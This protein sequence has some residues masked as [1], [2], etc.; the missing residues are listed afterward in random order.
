MNLPDG[1][2]LECQALFLLDMLNKTSHLEGEVVEIG[3]YL[4]RSSVLISQH[5]S[6]LHCIDT[7]H[8]YD[9]PEMSETSINNTIDNY[10]NFLINID[11]YNVKDRINIIPKKSEDVLKT[12]KKN[13]KF[14]FIDGCH[15]YKYIK[16]DIK[17]K[18][19][20][21]NEGITVFHDYPNWPGVKGAIDEDMFTDPNFRL[22]DSNDNIIA[23]QRRFTTNSR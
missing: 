3:S 1:H 5:V 2:L 8:F 9:I 21:V 11:K 18:K 23:F 22:I 7:W 15:D 17:W 14:I 10:N 4:G 19:F 13:I 16:K 6:K 20:V 12:W